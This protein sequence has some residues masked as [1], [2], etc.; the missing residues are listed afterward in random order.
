MEFVPRSTKSRNIAEV[1]DEFIC[2]DMYLIENINIAYCFCEQ[3]SLRILMPSAPRT[4]KGPKGKF[5]K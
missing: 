4:D 5:E 3:N 2:Y 1:M